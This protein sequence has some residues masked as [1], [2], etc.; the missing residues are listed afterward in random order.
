MH[1]LFRN[2]RGHKPLVSQRIEYVCQIGVRR[3]NK[4][5]LPFTVA[6]HRLKATELGVS[7]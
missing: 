2:R 7:R 3:R 1:N 6:V 4:W 5:S